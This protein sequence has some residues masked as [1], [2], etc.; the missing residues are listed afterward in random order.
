M[1]PVVSVIMPAFKAEKYISKSIESVLAQSFSDWE[2]IV[3]DDGSPDDLASVVRKYAAQD[4]RIR[5]ISQENQ[6]ACGARNRGIRE[7]DGKYVAFLDSDDV[8]LPDFLQK[9]VDEA[10]NKEALFVYCGSMIEN[11]D[12]KIRRL[13]FPYARKNVLKKFVFSEQIFHICGILIDR[14]TLLE[15][16]IEFPEATRFSE[17]I[18]FIIKVLTLVGSQVGVVPVELFKYCYQVGSVTHEKWSRAHEDTVSVLGRSADFIEIR[19]TGD[20]KPEI[21]AE[22]ARNQATQMAR[23]LWGSILRGDD[24]FSHYLVAEYPGV[25]RRSGRKIGHT[26]KLWFARKPCLW[27][28][29]RLLNGK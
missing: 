27:G 4:A 11:K 3:V 19:Y 9:M 26:V 15:A 29:I 18:E 23:T 24:E 21:L 1:K 2:L 14:S 8:W 10:E 6:G 16:R 28:V 5:L 12:G 7:A 25:I 13:G 22:L 17:D 20:D